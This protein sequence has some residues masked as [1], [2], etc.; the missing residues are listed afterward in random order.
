MAAGKEARAGNQ[1]AAR[2]SPD[3]SHPGRDRR[4]PERRRTERTAPPRLPPDSTPASASWLAGPQL[5]LLF[6]FLV[7]GRV[8]RSEEPREAVPG[9][10]APPAAAGHLPRAAP[11]RRRPERGW[12]QLWPAERSGSRRGPP[13]RLLQP[14]R[15][16]RSP[17][18]SSSRPL[19]SSPPPG[20]SQQ[21]R[22]PRRP[23]PA[24]C[25]PG[26]SSMGMLNSGFPH[27]PPQPVA[28]SSQVRADFK[29]G[30]QLRSVETP[31]KM[32]RQRAVQVLEP[33]HSHSKASFSQQG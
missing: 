2:S 15:H 19:R 8:P 10:A 31:G 23:Q 11:T 29:E 9:A 21:P 28:Q 16:E 20:R 6:L 4:K 25:W 3:V 32:Q 7:P 12:P 17:C 33:K 18:D 5:L 30:N 13:A 14:G 26:R 24:A 22:P 1:Q 27:K